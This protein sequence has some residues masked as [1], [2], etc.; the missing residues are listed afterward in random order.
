MN[1]ACCGGAMYVC[2]LAAMI[3]LDARKFWKFEPMIWFFSIS[4]FLVISFL[5]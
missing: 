4:S 1:V 2:S 3:H 5:I